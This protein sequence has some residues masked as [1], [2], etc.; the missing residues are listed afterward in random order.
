MSEVRNRDVGKS[1][2]ED[3]ITQ[4]EAALLLEQ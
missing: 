1:L 3:G 2:A 4:N